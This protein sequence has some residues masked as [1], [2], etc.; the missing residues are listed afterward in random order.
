MSKYLSNQKVTAFLRLLKPWALAVIFVLILRFTGALSGISFLATSVLLESGVMDANPNEIQGER[1]PFDYNFTIKDL[2]GN[3]VDFKQYQ[4]KV[5]FLNLWAT[6]CGPC[7]V[8]MPSIQELYDAMDKTK[9]SFVMLSLDSDEN[10]DKIVKYI[11]DK[12]FSFPVYQPSGYLPKQLRVNS[13]PT[14]FVIGADGKIKSKKVGA[15]NYSTDE[16]KEF[17]EGLSKPRPF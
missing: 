10:R 2:E 1:A 4:G 12:K 9:V 15:A 3:K 16:F 7:R 5:V 13:I 11:H 14:T 17:L 6:W 8:E